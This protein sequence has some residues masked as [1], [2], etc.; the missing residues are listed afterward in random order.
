MDYYL[1]MKQ[2]LLTQIS[3]LCQ[4]K[5]EN[6]E[7]SNVLE[8]NLNNLQNALEQIK[9]YNH[10]TYF[11]CIIKQ[12]N[13]EL[14]DSE[15]NTLRQLTEDDNHNDNN[16]Y[17]WIFYKGFKKWYQNL[18]NQNDGSLTNTARPETLFLGA[19]TEFTNYLFQ[20]ETINNNIGNDSEIYN[21]WQTLI[22]IKIVNKYKSHHITASDIM[23]KK[24]LIDV[25]KSIHYLENTYNKIIKSSLMRLSIV[26]NNIFKTTIKY[27]KYT[28]HIINIYDIDIFKIVAS[29][30]WT[31]KLASNIINICIINNNNIKQ[32]KLNKPSN[33]DE[34][35]KIQQTKRLSQHGQNK[36]TKI[37]LPDIPETPTSVNMDVK[38]DIEHDIPETPT[39]NNK[40]SDEINVLSEQQSFNEHVMDIDDVNIEEE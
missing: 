40:Q 18:Y 11:K 15:K 32:L 22:G 25:T 29:I 14:N 13:C 19:Q 10:N 37:D 23:D 34:A 35:F 26:E 9:S 31:P 38:I 1:S 2:I 36:S 33:F 30:L 21:I 24:S 12:F 20:N 27:N 4:Q 3:T 7:I 39:I 5:N 28:A 6:D 17:Q 16:Q 8:S